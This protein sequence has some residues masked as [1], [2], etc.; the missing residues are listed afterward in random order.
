MQQLDV[1][2]KN[3]GSSPIVLPEI[4][5]YTLAPGAEVNMMDAD[6]PLGHYSD[7]FA[8]IKALTELDGTVLYQQCAAGNLTFRVVPADPVIEVQHG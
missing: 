8:V 5:G 2:V 7:Y 6:L 4:G 1:Y 3:V